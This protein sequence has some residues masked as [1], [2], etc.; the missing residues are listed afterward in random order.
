MEP[1]SERWR[2]RKRRGR[3]LTIALISI[4]IAGIILAIALGVILCRSRETTE[5]ETCLTP[6]CIHTASNILKWMNPAIEP[7]D[8]FY[9]FACGNFI[10]DSKIR[11]DESTVSTSSVSDELVMEQ[12]RTL[13]EEPIQKSEAKPFTLLKKLYKACMNKT[14]IEQIGLDDVKQMLNDFGGWPVLQGQNWNSDSFDWK[15]TIFKFE[16]TGLYTDYLLTV[17]VNV[18]EKNS[19]RRV[20]NI[21]QPFLVL[22]REALIQGI[23]NEL[24]QA[25]YSYMADIAVI[26][27]AERGRAYNEMLNVVNFESKLAN[28]SYTIEE[29]R[30]SVALYNPMTIK[31]L[32]DTYSSIPWLRYINE[33]LSPYAT[34][35]EDE[36]VVVNSPK[37]LENVEKLIAVTDKRIQ[38]NY[39]LWR[40]VSFSISYLPDQLRTRQLQF[41]TVLTGETELLPRWKDCVTHCSSSLTIAADALYVRRYFKEDARKSAQELV[42]NIRTEF[43]ETLKEVDWMDEDT[44]QHALNKVDRMVEY[45]GYPNELLDDS[46]LEEYY[47]DLEVS[48]NSYLKS[49]LNV[50]LLS[51]KL[52]FKKLHMPVN[53]TDWSTHSEASAVNAFYSPNEN[54]IRK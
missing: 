25:Y 12:L 38:A 9:E 18:D 48:E 3:T 43:R 53:K 32:Q 4:I 45:I 8:D 37:Y 24:V 31:E 11:D 49:S 21:D 40:A 34:V 7:C 47:Q 29:A 17:N 33:L 19:S 6:E 13:F 46:K 26:F 14:R 15:D 1:N 44:R 35:T 10:K 20:L 41:N 54:S 22:S 39:L 42:H 16:E 27:G 52:S 36:V 51:N 2:Q 50:S 30:D 28:I 5:Q 23:A